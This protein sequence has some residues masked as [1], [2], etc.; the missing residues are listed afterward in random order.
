MTTDHVLK[1]LADFSF[2]YARESGYI[3]STEFDLIHEGRRYPPK[4]ILGLTAEH[5]IGRRLKSSE[6]SGGED[7]P[8]FRILRRLGFHIEKKVPTEMHI[9]K[10]AV[11]QRFQ[12]YNRE[13]IS[14]LFEPG[15][16]F[17]RGA[18]RWGMPG[19]VETPK[20]SGSFVLMV[21]L[22]RPVDGNPYHDVLTADGY[23]L[24]ESQ[25]Q[26]NFESRTIQK[27][28]AH[29]PQERNIHLFVRS[30]KASKYVYLGLLEYFSHDLSKRN[31]VHFVWRVRYWDLSPARL[32]ELGL[33][34][35]APR[36]PGYTPLRETTTQMLTREAVPPKLVI[37]SRDSKRSRSELREA[38]AV[39]WLERDLRNRHLGLQGEKLVVKYEI[40]MLRLAGRDDL[41]EQVCHVALHD[42]TAGFDIE[43][44]HAD[45]TPKLIEVKTTQGPKS[46]PF[47][48]SRNEVSAS[49]RHAE[50]YFVYRVFDYSASTGQVKFFE[51]KGNVEHSCGLVPVNFQAYPGGDSAA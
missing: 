3:D 21:T 10:R 5:V 7:T 38:S 2:A 36:D 27:L 6:F 23:L 42:S 46:T 47:F 26:H 13:E 15:V 19:I 22:G 40:E 50:S 14:Q 35:S 32:V 30:K 1:V 16:A 31:P 25:T 43:S 11:V 51:L 20:E 39:N 4:A 33:E 9:E 41:A 18:G 48:I 34:V 44:F 37:P 28:L 49:R 24:W 45:G 17:T 12:L 29:D 8:C